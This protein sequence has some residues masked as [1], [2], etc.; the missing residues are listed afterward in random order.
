MQKISRKPGG[1]DP[2]EGR[3]LGW[4]EHDCIECLELLGDQWGLHLQSQTE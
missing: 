1:D 2:S 3:F 4:R